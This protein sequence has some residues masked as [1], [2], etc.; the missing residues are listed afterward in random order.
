M[1]LRSGE[2]HFIDRDPSGFDFVLNYLRDGDLPPIPQSDVA[3]NAKIISHF[4]YFKIPFHQTLVV[5]Q[6]KPAPLISPSKPQPPL[7]RA[8]ET[9]NLIDTSLDDS[10]LEWSK[11][12]STKNVSIEGKRATLKVAGGFEYCA[13]AIG[14]APNPKSFKVYVFLI[15]I[16]D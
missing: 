3:L 4:E 9:P 11:E 8:P 13:A 6:E 12:K 2:E 16:F 5:P 1:S 15:Y 14:T 10:N 7:S